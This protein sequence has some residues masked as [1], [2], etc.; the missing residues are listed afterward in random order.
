MS[1]NQINISVNA[2]RKRTTKKLSIIFVGCLI[3][4]GCQ[5]AGNFDLISNSNIVEQNQSVANTAPIPLPAIKTVKKATPTPK[6]ELK[7]DESGGMTG[8]QYIDKPRLGEHYKPGWIEDQQSDNGFEPFCVQAKI[9]GKKTERCGYQNAEGKVLIKPMFKIVYVFS[10]GYAG[11]CPKKDDLCG[12]INEKGILVIKPNYQFVGVFSESLAVIS[13]GDTDFYKY[14][15]INKKGKYVIRLQYS[16]ASA[17]RSGVAEVTVQR[18]L[19]KCIN[20]ENENV[21]CLK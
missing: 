8:L 13:I 7:A 20:K 9:K 1:N 17:F 2:E 3:F 16:N 18:S 10:E 6:I 21:E 19:N 15:Y 5:S 12:Y 4:V 14:G 11:V